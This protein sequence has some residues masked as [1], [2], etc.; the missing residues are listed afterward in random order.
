MISEELHIHVKRFITMSG[1]E[2]ETHEQHKYFCT[3][4]VLKWGVV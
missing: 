3:I 4:S 1:G 2:W